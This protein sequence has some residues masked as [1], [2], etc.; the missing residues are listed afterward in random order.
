MKG[1]VFNALAKLPNRKKCAYY[2][3][4]GGTLAAT[5]SIVAVFAGDYFPRLKE[6]QTVCVTKLP[7]LK[8]DRFYDLEPNDEKVKFIEHITRQVAA[9]TPTVDVALPEQM[10]DSRHSKWPQKRD[11]DFFMNWETLAW[12]GELA[13][14]AKPTT[15]EIK[16]NGRHKPARIAFRGN[17]FGVKEIV[18]YAMGL[19]VQNEGETAS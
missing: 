3:T 4:D 14:A 13:K 12:L 1:R 5:D 15:V 6:E 17:E 18:I 19:F 16:L 11:A 10:Y 8:G 7:R 2:L 9:E